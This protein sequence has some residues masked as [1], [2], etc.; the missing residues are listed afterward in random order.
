MDEP[1]NSSAGATRAP[2]PPV[3]ASLAG[4]QPGHDDEVSRSGGGFGGPPQLGGLFAGGMPTLKK[5]GTGV[6]T[7]ELDLFT[8]SV[9]IRR[10]AM[11][12]IERV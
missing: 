10:Q 2:P 8:V 11:R 4:H 5:T 9:S 6:N 3:A 1:G 7:G 12:S